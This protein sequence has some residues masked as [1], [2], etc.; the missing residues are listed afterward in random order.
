MFRTVVT[1]AS[2]GIGRV[3]ALLLAKD[4]HSLVLTARRESELRSL[5][6]ACL[7]GGAVSVGVV[8]GDLTHQDL[9]PQ[10]ADAVEISGEGEVVLVNN[11]GNA[12]FGPFD[13]MPIEQSVGMVDLMLSGSM[14]AAHALLPKMLEEGRGTIVN[15]LSVAAIHSFPG[16][17]A[18]CAAKAGLLA[19]SRSLSLSYRDK[20]IRVTSLIPG[21]TDTPLW[22][23]VES[24]P[25]RGDML[26][27]SAVAETIRMVISA[28]RDRSFDEVVLT[29]PRGIL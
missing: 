18:Y 25:D 4:G 23:S 22:D 10:L 3:T 28:P 2:S 21:A 24:G 29:P 9:A 6:D 5:A 11:A 26:S 15:V 20:G 17:E 12:T 13:G 16:A 1:G 7:V 14:R 8:A 19:F 27:A